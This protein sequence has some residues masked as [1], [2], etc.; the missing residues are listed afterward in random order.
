MY[1]MGKEKLNARPLDKGRPPSSRAL[2]TDNAYVRKALKAAHQANERFWNLEL[3]VRVK[4]IYSREDLD[5]EWGSKTERW[6]AAMTDERRTAI[7]APS[8]F[9]RLTDRKL[10]EY[11]TILTHEICHAFYERFVG[12]GRPAWLNEGIAMTVAMQGRRYNGEP[13]ASCLVYDYKDVDLR[14]ASGREFYRSS[15]LAVKRI[16]HKRGKGRLL[17][18]LRAYRKDPCLRNYQSLRRRLDVF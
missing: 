11:P 8:V 10:P 9:E 5:R 3:P 2:A 6:L 16:L 15:Y 1:A 17:A 4:L 13:D 7:L 12:T 18:F 14:G